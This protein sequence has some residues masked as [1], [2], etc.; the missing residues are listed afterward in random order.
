ME[1]HFPTLPPEVPQRGNALSRAL[2]K[3]LF[4]LKVGL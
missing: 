4:W 3:K 1:Q 2:F